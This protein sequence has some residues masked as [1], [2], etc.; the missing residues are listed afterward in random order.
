MFEDEYITECGTLIFFACDEMQMIRLRTLEV[1]FV[2]KWILYNAWR[3]QGTLLL[4]RWRNK[5]SFKQCEGEGLQHLG[6]ARGSEQLLMD[7]E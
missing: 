2:C 6:A 5:D 7:G 3:W 1:G 4:I